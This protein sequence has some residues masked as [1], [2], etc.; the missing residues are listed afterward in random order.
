[1]RTIEGGRPG[2]PPLDYQEG[3]WRRIVVEAVERETAKPKPTA[4]TESAENGDALRTS[5]GEEEGSRFDLEFTSIGKRARAERVIGSAQR[6]LIDAAIKEAINSHDSASQVHNTLY[7]LLLPNPLKG[8]ARETENM[9]LVLDRGATDYPWEMLATRRGQDRTEPLSVRIGMLRRLIA[10]SFRREINV[11]TGFNALVIGDPPAEPLP[12]L[13]EARAEARRVTE[14]LRSRGY[15]VTTAISEEGEDA[16]AYSPLEILNSLF[17]H[18]YRVIHIAAHGKFDAADRARSGFY[19]GPNQLLTSIELRQLTAIPDLVFFNCCHLGRMGDGTEQ[20][21][22]I[23]EF[24]RLAASVS[25][26]LIE[27]GVRTVVAAGWAVN[28]AAAEEFAASFYDLMLSGEVLGNAVRRARAR[29]HDR[30]PRSNTWGAYQV[31]G[32]P[33]FTLPT[34][35]GGG[36]SD[37]GADSFVAVQEIIRRLEDIIRRARRGTS[38]DK[39]SLVG[40]LE[41]VMARTPSDWVGGEVAY[42]HAEA[43]KEIGRTAEAIERYEH[44]LKT[45]DGEVRMDALEQLANQQIRQAEALSRNPEPDSAVIDELV[46]SSKKR[47]VQLLDIAPTPERHSL[48]GSYH[49]RLCLMAT[50]KSDRLEHLA[51]AAKHYGEAN[52]QHVAEKNVADYYPLLNSATFAYVA[53]MYGPTGLAPTRQQKLLK[54]VDTAEQAAVAAEAKESSF[55]TR[56][57]PADA[58]VLRALVTDSIGDNHVYAN[59]YEAFKKAFESPSTKNERDSSIGNVRFIGQLLG[60]IKHP[61]TSHLITL[62]AELLDLSQELG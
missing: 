60:Y 44:A 7:E 53:A 16:I 1:M 55:W 47:F 32:D 35:H 26:Q 18:D 29:V 27:E 24:H 52:E 20:A 3:D 31:Y 15:E 48:F 45:W 41:A 51:A 42:L 56:V 11:A 61:A 46:R 9:L 62:E 39:K 8:E 30:F 17:E 13:P 37:G 6:T 4:Q 23:G 54:D 25:E 10:R 57:T 33:G 50:T 22:A 59:V 21:G 34:V 36:V 19:I 43:L 40:R 14:Q 38:D 2:Q 12:R 49:K 58:T 5:G 28:D